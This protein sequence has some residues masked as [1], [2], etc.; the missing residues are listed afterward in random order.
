[1]DG[2]LL[3]VEVFSKPTGRPDKR[4]LV[5]R[6]YVLPDPETARRLVEERNTML[7]VVEREMEIGP[8]RGD[9]EVV[10]EDV[11]Y[12]YQDVVL[13]LHSDGVCFKPLQA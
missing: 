5:V 4:V 8:C 13:V 7:A 11:D 10:A 3:L 12:P 1:M 2:E 6:A 9:E